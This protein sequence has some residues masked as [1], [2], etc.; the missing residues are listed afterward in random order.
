MYD[1]V[2]FDM[3]GVL[4]DSG[5]DDFYWMDRK[6]IQEFDN[7]GYNI[8][9]EDSIKL[10][11]KSGESAFDLIESMEISFEELLEIEE[12]IQRT[13]IRMI[14]NGYI[15]LFPGA[16]R[17]LEKI[18]NIALATNSPEMSTAFTLEFFGIKNQFNSI[19]SVKL[20]KGSLFQ[21]KKPEPVMLDEVIEE[22]GF[23][24]T[25]MIGDSS[26]DI[27]AAENAGIDSV[28]VESYRESS[29]LD[30]TY[31]VRNISEALTV[32]R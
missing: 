22:E 24:N 10:I 11:K 12:E 30:P 16:S 32:L 23:E 26:S 8:S 5:L 25:V 3:D 21:R 17:V 31:R 2:I 1:G 9:S 6:R 20:E 28:L 29:N 27:K 14:K 15:R 7:R 19:K 4:L 18:D 13:K